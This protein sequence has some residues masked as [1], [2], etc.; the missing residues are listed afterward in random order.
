MLRVSAKVDYAVR[1]LVV[2]ARVTPASMKGDQLAAEQSIPFRFLEVT[3]S[4]LRHAGLVGSR[5][6]ADGGYW[7]VG[8]PSEVTVRD[9]VV[10][11]EG[12]VADLR[13]LNGSGPRRSGDRATTAPE[14]EATANVWIG[15]GEH[16][17][18][19]L[20]TISLA[21]LVARAGASASAA[22]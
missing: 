7:L 11:V 13:S 12:S 3:L 4:E 19:H 5:R 16:L 2:L 18:D 22:S 17:D 10:A 14:R 20:A 21:D 1:A 8:D 6:G 15:A 9:I